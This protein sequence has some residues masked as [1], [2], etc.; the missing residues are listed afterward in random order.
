MLMKKKFLIA[1]IIAISIIFS[2][3]GDTT[4]KYGYADY[5]PRVKQTGP[6]MCYCAVVQMLIGTPQ[7][8]VANAYRDFLFEKTG[9]IDDADYTEPE[10]AYFFEGVDFEYAIEFWNQLMFDNQSFW[11]TVEMAYT[12][13]S[14]PR[15]L[16]CLGIC[17]NMF[18]SGELS[19][20]A[21]LLHYVTVTET[22]RGGLPETVF[23]VSF[24]DPETGLPAGFAGKQG[25]H[26]DIGLNMYVM[27]NR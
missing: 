22:L 3:Y 26:G 21:V 11:G 2:V 5:W 16:P 1:G 20:H 17:F 13:Y 9:L 6:G 7:G 27:L 25:A 4:K 14:N 18:H 23:H 24:I 15:R 12:L 8:K 10:A 19:V